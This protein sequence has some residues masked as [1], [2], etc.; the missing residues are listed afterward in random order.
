MRIL[1][2]K[3]SPRRLLRIIGL[4]AI[5]FCVLCAL[6]ALIEPRLLLVREVSVT[7]PEVPAE[8]DGMRIAFAVDVHAGSLLG[9]ERTRRIVDV[10]NELNADVIVLGGDNVG[11]GK[12]DNDWFYAEAARLKAPMGVYTVLGNHEAGGNL[13][14]ARAHLPK[15]GIVLLE[16][17]SVRLR[18]GTGSLRLAGVADYRSGSPDFK[19]VAQGTRADGYSIVVSHNPDALVEGLP[20]SRGGFDLALSGHT[21]GGQVTF[22]GLWAPVSNSEYGQRFVHGWTTVDGVPVLASKG[23][24]VFALPLRFFAPP[25]IH[26]IELHRGS[27]LITER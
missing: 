11:G 21:H 13:A 26:L 27:T 24:G 5:A 6:W 12:H 1:P 18:S 19:A 22:F 3:G 2:A 9:R 4:A 23:A 10:V 14:I 16:N 25:E 8:F 17:E 15:A 7:H 20:A